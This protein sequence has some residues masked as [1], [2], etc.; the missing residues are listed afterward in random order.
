[1]LG[2]VE[3]MV[4]AEYIK[5]NTEDGRTFMF[6]WSVECGEKGTNEIYV[7]LL[8]SPYKGVFRKEYLILF[9]LL[10]SCIYIHIFILML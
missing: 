6:S 1:M 5:R 4:M 2:D 3:K 8:C 9:I 7:C 10:V